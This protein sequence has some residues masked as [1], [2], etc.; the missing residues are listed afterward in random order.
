MEYVKQFENEY[1]CVSY[2]KIMPNEEVGLHYDIYPQKV[3]S[4]HGG[5]I[6]RLEADGTVTK[7]CFPAGEWIYRPSESADKMHKSVN[8]TSEPVELVIVQLK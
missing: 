3:K 5:V 1:I 8:A 6:T 7:V 4:L 2:V